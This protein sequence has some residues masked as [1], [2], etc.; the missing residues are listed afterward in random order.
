MKRGFAQGGSGANF[1]IQWE[2]QTET[3]PPVVEAVHIDNQAGRPYSFITT[4]RA[5]NRDK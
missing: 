5:V 2:A 4:A 3:N 1:I